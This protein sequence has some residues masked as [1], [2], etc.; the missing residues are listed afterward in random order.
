M[1]RLGDDLQ[2]LPIFFLALSRRRITL[3]MWKLYPRVLQFSEKDFKPEIHNTFSFVSDGEKK[4][5]QNKCI[6]TQ[7][8]LIFIHFIAELMYT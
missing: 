6:L 4:C 3:A 5:H 1:V 7:V 8:F 2:M